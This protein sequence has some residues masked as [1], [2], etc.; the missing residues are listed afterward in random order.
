M[1]LKVVID[2]ESVVVEQVEHIRA[3]VQVPVIALAQENV[4][5]RPAIGVDESSSISV[6]GGHSGCRQQDDDNI[7]HNR[8]HVKNLDSSTREDHAAPGTRRGQ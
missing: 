5:Q 3:D 1:R 2:V 4:E 8:S 6:C 7:H